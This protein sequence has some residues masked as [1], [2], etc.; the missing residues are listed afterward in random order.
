MLTPGGLRPLRKMIDT[1]AYIRF[2]VT[3][4]TVAAR[5]MVPPKA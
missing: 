3:S 4:R 5:T 2:L 1:Q